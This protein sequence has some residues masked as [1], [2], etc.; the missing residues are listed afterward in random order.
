MLKL[1]SNV[2]HSRQRHNLSPYLSEVPSPRWYAP[3]ST[4]HRSRMVLFTSASPESVLLY[5]SYHRAISKLSLLD[6]L[7]CS[8]QSD[9]STNFH[10]LHLTASSAS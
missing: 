8:S 5:I 2:S 1:G 9:L 6:N 10:R 4:S 7:S 3:L